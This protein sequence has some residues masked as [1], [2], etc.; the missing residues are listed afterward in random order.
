M[1]SVS[2]SLTG[3]QWDM[4]LSQYSSDVRSHLQKHLQNVTLLCHP[5]ENCH[6]SKYK[7][8]SL[9]WDWKNQKMVS[10]QILVEW[11]AKCCWL[12]A[13]SAGG[14]P[15]CA[16]SWRCSPWQ[17]TGWLEVRGGIAPPA[18]WYH[19]VLLGERNNYRNASWMNNKSLINWLIK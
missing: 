11:K 8:L 6:F 14:P 13:E 10:Y 1:I 3:R 9:Y 12:R 19:S 2:Y 7:G 4:K 5:Y 17:P 15:M 16:L 18:C